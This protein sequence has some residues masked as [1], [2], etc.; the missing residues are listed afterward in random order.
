MRCRAV[1]VALLLFV[2]SSCAKTPPAGPPASVP[3]KYPN[4]PTPTVPATL[5]VA[6][7]LLD[8]HNL[9]WRRL[10]AGDLRGAT[11]DFNEVLK[12]AADFYPAE[13]GIGFALL[14]DE[15]YKQAA[16]RFG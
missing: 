6:P 15:E 8:R 2:V 3:P 14:A 5:L 9:G 11:R 1:A 12:H 16:I 4:Y 13:T 10:Q 7:D